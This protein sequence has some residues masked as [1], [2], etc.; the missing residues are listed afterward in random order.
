MIGMTTNVKK[1][2][3]Y[4]WAI[5]IPLIFGGSI[6][7]AAATMWATPGK[8][9]RNSATA[10]VWVAR[11]RQSKFISE[12]KDYAGRRS[13]KFS[14]NIVPAPWK[15]VGMTM[16]TPKENEI[17]II[18]ATAPDKFAIAITVDHPE[19]HWQSYWDHIRSYISAR[20]KWRD[21]LKAGA[22]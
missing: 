7:A 19:E 1:V 17:S 2:V 16:L 6:V 4:K 12:I 3:S 20:Y 18:N 9:A 21:D 10:W 11:E 14:S 15:M 13:L 22:H 5:I 8:F